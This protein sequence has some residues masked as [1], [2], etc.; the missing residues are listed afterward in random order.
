MEINQQELIAVL[1]DNIALYQ[2]LGIE[3]TSI[4]PHEVRLKVSLKKSH[5][6]KGTAFGGSL[7]ASAV[8][9][10]YALVLA[11]LKER[12]IPTENIVIAKGEIE[13]LRPVDTDYEII[14]KFSSLQK[15]TVFFEELR[16]KKKVR[17]SLVSEIKGQDQSLRARLTGLFVVKL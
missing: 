4:T 6:H 16:D 8:L 2:H 14:C 17:G 15:E 9:A 12:K 3:E 10:A 11:G 13:Y 1:K 5:N 7:Y